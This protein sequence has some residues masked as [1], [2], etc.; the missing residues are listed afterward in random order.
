MSDAYNEYPH[1]H[2]GRELKVEYYHDSDTGPPWEEQTKRPGEMV[3]ST[4]GAMARF[5]D[6]QEA[7][8][9]AR[10][11]E[12]GMSD[13]QPTWTKGQ[14]AHEAAY[15]DYLRL[16]EW[17]HDGWHWMGVMV[18]D[19]ETGESL[20]LWGIESDADDYICSVRNE[21]AEELYLPS[22]RALIVGDAA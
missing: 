20:S 16:K 21:L 19:V 17:C 4:D 6:F 8:A 5:Y 18:T 9:I 14:I 7:V 12:W 15:R 2:K 22:V 11:D 3:L 1:T 10:R 13:A